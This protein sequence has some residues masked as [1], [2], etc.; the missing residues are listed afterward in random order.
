MIEDIKCQE[1]RPNSSVLIQSLKEE[2][3]YLQNENLNKTS[4]MKS[5]TENHCVPTNINSAV[6]PPNLHHE[7][8]QDEKHKSTTNKLYESPKTD[9]KGII[10]LHEIKSKGNQKINQDLR[11]NIPQRKETLIL[12]DSIVKHVEGWRLNKRMKSAVSIRHIPGETKKAM[13]HHLQGCLENIFPDNIILN[14]ETNNLNSD[15]NS[16]KTASDIVD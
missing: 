4:I 6:F 14:H 7:K 10:I 3:S 2:L 15:D 8:G 5:L 9:G 13:K 16:G 12:G 1:S 11:S